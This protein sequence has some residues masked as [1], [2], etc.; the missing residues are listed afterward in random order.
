MAGRVKRVSRLSPT[1]VFPVASVALL[2]TT[3]LVYYFP[4]TSRQEASL[5]D[6][7]LRHLAAVRAK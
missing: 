2:L 7:A 6:R 3:F 5:N 4:I 1:V